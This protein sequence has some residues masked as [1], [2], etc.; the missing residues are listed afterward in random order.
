MASKS[1][2]ADDAIRGEPF[3]RRLRGLVADR[4]SPEARALLDELLRYTRARVNRLAARQRSGLASQEVDEIVATVL[5]DLLRGGLASF[6]GDSLPE[7]IAFT[8]TIADRTTW[9]FLRRAQRER[10]ALDQA[11]ADGLAPVGAHAF[12]APDA[13]VEPMVQSPLTEP[14]VVYL[15]ALLRAGSK[16]ELARHAGVSRAA[17]TQ[18]VQRI[19]ERVGALSDDQLARHVVWL[20]QEATRSLDEVG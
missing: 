8:R 1:P 18:R 3:R 13:H 10:D 20:R 19:V 2:L 12:S 4:R 9:R 11:G 6:R 14:D 5:L 17:V 7:L 15:Q 16:A